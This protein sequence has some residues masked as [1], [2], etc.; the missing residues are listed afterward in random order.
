MVIFCDDLPFIV[1]AKGKIYNYTG[2]NMK[3]LYVANPSE[4]KFLVNEANRLCTLSNLLGS[5]LGMLPGFC[6]K[7]NNALCNTKESEEQA[8]TTPEALT[9]DTASTLDNLHNDKTHKE[10]NNIETVAKKCFSR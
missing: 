9:I 10:G 6:R 3:Q 5:V 4:H 2:G 8:Q 1:S 7:Q